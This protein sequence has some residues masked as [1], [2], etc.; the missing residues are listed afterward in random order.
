MD[1][2]NKNVFVFVVCGAKEHIE[3]LHFSLKYLK[4]FSKNEICI[5]TDSTR[6]EVAIEHENI[7]DVATPHHYN[8]HQASIFLK[9]GIHLFLPVGPIYCYLDTDVIALDSG[10]D[11]IF[12]EYKSPI[13]FAPDHCKMPVFSPAATHCSCALQHKE[14]VAQLESLLAKYDANKLLASPEKELQE[15]LIYQFQKAKQNKFSYAILVLKYLLSFHKF[16]FGNY[17]LNKKEKIWYAKKSSKAIL[18]DFSLIAK[19]IQEESSFTWSWWKRVWLNEAGKNIYDL[20]C[21]H[22]KEKIQETFQIAVKDKNWQHWNGG[23]FLFN[24]SSKDFLNAWHRK[25]VEIFTLD[26]W[27]TRDQGTLIATV[28]EFGLEKHPTLSKKWNFLADYYKQGL[29]FNEEGYFTDNYWKEK[30]KVSFL[31]IYHHWGN[32]DW[33]IWNWTLNKLKN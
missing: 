1:G 12:K 15:D 4:H 23:V 6:N 10:V 17:Y 3:T 13:S 2:L 8:N 33:K 18:Y 27:K 21:N 7:I 28:W 22:L 16:D 5:L 11:Q 26:T 20:H 9:T 31:H 24:N 30:Y 19:K 29:D 14:E 32:E 25:S